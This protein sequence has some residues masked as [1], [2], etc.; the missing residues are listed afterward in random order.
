MYC[1]EGYKTIGELRSS[2][3]GFEWSIEKYPYQ[4]PSDAYENLVFKTILENDALRIC[5]PTGTILKVSEE[6]LDKIDMLDFFSPESFP[7]SH[8]AGLVRDE[9][10]EVKWRGMPLFFERHY[11]TVSLSNYREYKKVALNE[12]REE[13]L[14]D[15]VCLPFEL[16]PLWHLVEQFEGYSLCAV[17]D[18]LP[19]E[20]HNRAGE[21]ETFIRNKRGRPTERKAIL[22]FY[23]KNFGNGHSSW[24]QVQNDLL[25][26][27]G[28]DVH[29]DTIKRA[30][31]KNNGQKSQAKRKIFVPFLHSLPQI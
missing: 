26:Q 6:I 1:P 18:K 31:G 7:I 16:D 20:I 12:Y 10:G 3:I 2:V 28:I 17:A 25:S 15:A 21:L 27:T 24:K 23:T 8:F 19:N 9:S 29:I 13:E 5:S 14:W 11:Y 30:L 4:T 22:A